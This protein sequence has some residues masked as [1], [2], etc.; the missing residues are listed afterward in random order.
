MCA[1]DRFVNLGAIC[2]LFLLLSPLSLYAATSYE[3]KSDFLELHSGP[4]DAFP[5]FYVVE[6]GQSAQLVEQQSQWYLLQV[7]DQVRG[8]ASVESLYDAIGG[9]VPAR[10]SLK[11]GRKKIALGYGMFQQSGEFGIGAGYRILPKL[12]VMLDYKKIVDNVSS[13][14]AMQFRLDVPMLASIL[15]PTAMIGVGVLNNQ[16]SSLLAGGKQEQSQYILYGVGLK[17]RYLSGLSFVVAAAGN[18][19]L[20]GNSSSVLWNYRFEVETVF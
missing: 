12:D 3:I 19:L 20:N 5:V 8:W 16:P 4:S 11:H 2:F 17:Y 14:S 1:T 10:S 9:F 18:S 15:T 13:S 7:G 6:Q